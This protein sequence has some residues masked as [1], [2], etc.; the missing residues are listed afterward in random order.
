MKRTTYNEWIEQLKKEWI[1]KTVSYQGEQFKV[2]NVD[3]NGML[4]IDKPHCYTVSY[5]AN[6]TAISINHLD[7]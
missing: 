5:T 7:K 1:G 6:H 2:V 4:W 3:Y